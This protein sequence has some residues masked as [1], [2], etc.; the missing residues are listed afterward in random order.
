MAE[1]ARTLPARP[2][3][4]WR[5]FVLDQLVGTLL[6]REFGAGRLSPREFAVLSTIGATRPITPTDLAQLL[7]MPATTLSAVL[8]RFERDGLVARTRNPD[9]GRSVLLE[10]TQEGERRIRES[11]PRI[12]TAI[13]AVGAN[14]DVPLEDVQAA[15]EAYERAARR[16]LD[17]S[18]N[19]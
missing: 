5:L 18:A 15:L 16:A 17:G 3:V 2:N 8:K 9:D 13:D 19:A 11:L 10:P 12:R 7:G 1:P 4:V 14:L 6:E